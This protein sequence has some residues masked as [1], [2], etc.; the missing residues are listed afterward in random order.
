MKNRIGFIQLTSSYET[1][2][3]HATLATCNLCH[4]IFTSQT[5]L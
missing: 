1:S 4:G 3:L 2:L 5:L